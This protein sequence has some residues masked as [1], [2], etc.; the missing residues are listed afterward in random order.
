MNII[1]YDKIEFVFEDFN[2]IFPTNIIDK[3]EVNKVQ[4][5][6]EKK[7]NPNDEYDIYIVINRMLAEILWKKEELR[8]F[9]RNS[10]R[11][12]NVVNKYEWNNTV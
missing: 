8:N 9:E 2:L 12:E 10:Y 1:D 5:L 6:I 7:Y 4:T 11:M 3:F